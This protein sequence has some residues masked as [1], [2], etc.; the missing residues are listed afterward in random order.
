MKANKLKAR[1]IE[2]GITA[3]RL[4][5][6]MGINIATFYRKLKNNYFTLKDASIM[7]QIL[8]LSN[9]DIVDI[10]FED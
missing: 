9:A 7:S 6:Y 10:F 2:R 5:E 8:E 1:M 4:S 3:A